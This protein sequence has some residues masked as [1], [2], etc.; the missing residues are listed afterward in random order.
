MICLYVITIYAL[1]SG[2]INLRALI[3]APLKS[4]LHDR[5]TFTLIFI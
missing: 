2:L 4:V 3:K 5:G 1:G